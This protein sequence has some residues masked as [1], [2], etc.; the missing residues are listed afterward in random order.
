MSQ[1]LVP[2][3]DTFNQILLQGYYFK[4][5][6][7]LAFCVIKK[8][9]LDIPLAELNSGINAIKSNGIRFDTH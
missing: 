9:I 8:K 7:T 5:I 2:C 4:L 6:Q 3:R 1:I